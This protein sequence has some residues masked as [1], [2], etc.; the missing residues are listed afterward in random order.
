MRLE[1]NINFQTAEGFECVMRTVAE[2]DIRDDE[3]SYKIIDLEMIE[4]HGQPVS[5]QLDE[6]DIKGQIA[7]QIGA[8][9]DSYIDDNSYELLAA[10]SDYHADLAYDRWKESREHE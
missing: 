1:L 7:S 9:L 6:M 2:A 5:V 10:E 3:Y 4:F 8:Y